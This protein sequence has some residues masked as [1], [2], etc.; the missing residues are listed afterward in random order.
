LRYTFDK[1]EEGSNPLAN[2]VKIPVQKLVHDLTI[3]ISDQKIMEKYGL[4]YRQLILALGKL[5]E[6]R[7]ISFKRIVFFVRGYLDRGELEKAEVCLM[8]IKKYFSKIWGVQAIV[9]GL[10]QE[11]ASLKSRKAFQ[12]KMEEKS[13][14]LERFKLEYPETPLHPAVV[15]SV[16]VLDYYTDKIH[17]KKKIDPTILKLLDARSRL[18]IYPKYVHRFAKFDPIEAT[19]FWH[20]ISLRLFHQQKICHFM[21]RGMMD[22][23]TRDVCMHL[24]GTRLS[25]NE[26]L[27]KAIEQNMS[28]KVLPVNYFPALM[29]VED[30]SP[31]R[32]ARV[33]MKNGWYLPPF[34]ES[35]RCQIFP[36]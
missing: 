17:E 21:I 5:A 11:L 12:R 20:Y 32:K 31:E 27:L 34:C 6:R 9:K 29:D 35:C 14:S 4:D 19:R 23:E 18:K 2:K 15:S 7:M 8:I 10:Q 28:E 26:V 36:S 22:A 1:K 30:L 16:K 25:V 24:D 13:K 33:L 3:G